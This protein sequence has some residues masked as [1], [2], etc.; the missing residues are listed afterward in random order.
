MSVATAGV[1]QAAASV[2]LS[3]H[4]S[5]SEA[6]ATTQACAVVVAQVGPGDVTDQLDPL[7][8]LVLLDPAH[9]VELASDPRR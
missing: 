6:L 2:R 1:P 5:T 9:E 3:P 4:P 8:G 7:L